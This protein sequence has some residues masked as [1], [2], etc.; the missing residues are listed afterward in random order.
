[1]K[2]ADFGMARVAGL[3]CSR[4][5]FIHFHPFST[6]EAFNLPIPKYTHEAV[7]KTLAK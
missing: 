5:V 4:F 1:M 2:I 3:D 7:K 6:D